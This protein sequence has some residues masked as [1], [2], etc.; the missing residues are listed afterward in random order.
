MKMKNPTT[1]VKHNKTPLQNT[2]N[3]FPVLQKQEKI[4]IYRILSRFIKK[5]FGMNKRSVL[6]YWL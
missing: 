3:Y 5:K 2:R 4:T 1:V 6:N